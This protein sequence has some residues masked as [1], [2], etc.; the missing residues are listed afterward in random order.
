VLHH[1]FEEEAAWCPELKSQNHDQAFLTQRFR[2]EYERYAGGA[3]RDDLKE[4]RSFEPLS[5]TSPPS[6]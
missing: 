2:E 3:T 6:H 1:I 4:P 5:S